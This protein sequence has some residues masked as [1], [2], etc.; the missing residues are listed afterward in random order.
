[1]IIALSPGFK[2]LAAPG[3]HLDAELQKNADAQLQLNCMTR[4]VY[5]MMRSHKLISYLDCSRR[6]D[7]SILT[8]LIQLGSLMTAT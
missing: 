3:S 6:L 4:R 8:I 2:A 5:L 1:M 7:A